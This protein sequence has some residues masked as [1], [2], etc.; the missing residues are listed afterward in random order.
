MVVLTGLDRLL[1]DP[2]RWLRG[3]KFGLLTNDAA[4]SADGVQGRR[5]LTDLCGADMLALFSPEHG[6]TARTEDALGVPDRREGDK[7]VYSLY[8]P[9]GLRAPT[10]EMLT[11]LEVLVVD[12]QDVGVRY[13]TYLS[14][15]LECIRAAHAQGIPVLVLDR[16]NPLGGHAV[17]GPGVE[18]GGENF[19]A[20]FDVP[21]RHG[22]TLGEL[23]LLATR[24]LGLPSA[25]VEVVPAGGWTRDMRWEQTGLVWYPPSPAA[26]SLSMVAVYPGSCLV[27][28]TNVSEGRG[29]D[30]PFELIGAPWLDGGELARELTAMGTRDGACTWPAVSPATFR[31]QAWKHSGTVCRGV[32]I[33]PPPGRHRGPT[34]AAGPGPVAFGVALLEALLRLGGPEFAWRREADG[35]YWLDLLAGGPQL[36]ESLSG[37]ASWRDIQ[38]DWREREDEHREEMQD[39]LLY[40]YREEKPGL[41]WARPRAAP[42]GAAGGG[43]ELDLMS[44]GEVAAAL[45]AASREAVDAVWPAVPEIARAIGAAAER[46]G[47]GGRLIYAGAGTS[48]RL[49]VLDAS[50]CEPTFGVGSGTVLAL[51]AGGS[52]AVW[53]SREAAEDDA[54]AGEDAVAEFEVGPND[55]LVGVSAGG[56]TPFTLAAVT[57]AK[58]RGA[59]TVAVTARTSTPLAQAADIIVETV[60][61]QEP[62]EGSTRLKAGTAHKVV[63]NALS[64]G[65]FAACGHVHGNKM[66]G[67]RPVSQKLRERALSLVTEITGAGG[68]RAR[69]ALDAALTVDAGLAVRIAVLHL[70]LGVTPPEA[71]RLLVAGGGSLRRVLCA[72]RPSARP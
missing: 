53:R 4:R 56:R 14:T 12:L 10:P 9:G 44:P 3:R 55:V 59:L 17:E 36:R 11:G 24:R 6:L 35:A 30:A 41:R 32:R 51:I 70:V 20:A 28:G 15:M 33:V 57:A 61:G 18:P 62:L 65:V 39:L 67:V 34:A 23:A 54:A 16:P 37:G 38:E 7:P 63:L 66:I 40:P 47:A 31:P 45:V 19:V 72:R 58:E 25:A 69:E 43:L 22:L 2:G 21:V 1:S 60:T 52:E 42:E 29:T 50:E 46:V 68:E 8:G 13:Y 71:H 26:T 27:E 64:T 5:T 49:G 48:G